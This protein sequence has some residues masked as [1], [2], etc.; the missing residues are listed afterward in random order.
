[1]PTIARTVRVIVAVM[2]MICEVRTFS[3]SSRS[4]REGPCS[5]MPQPPEIALTR[6]AAK[7]IIAVRGP[8]AQLVRAVDS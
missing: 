3:R 7:R 8:I 1:M 4:L 6:R 2:R 5:A